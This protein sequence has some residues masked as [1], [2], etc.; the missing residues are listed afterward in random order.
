MCQSQTYFGH[1]ALRQAHFPIREGGLG[2]TSRNLIEGAA[3]NGCLALVTRRA[4]VSSVWGNLAYLLELLPGR[5]MASSLL[6][7]LKAMA[8]EVKKSQID[9][10]MGSSWE[11]LSV[12]EDSQGKGLRTLL[13]KVGAGGGRGRG[14][15]DV[16]GGW[17]SEVLNSKNNGRTRWQPSL[18]GNM[19]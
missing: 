18:R 12:E 2:L 11:T 14:G 4:V 19:R 16:R 15:Q 1:E 5:P 3:Y 6:K 13:L 7:E 17:V 8:T 9:D 10:S